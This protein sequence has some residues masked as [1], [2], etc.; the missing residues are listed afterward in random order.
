MQVLTP[1]AVCAVIVPARVAVRAPAACVPSEVPPGSVVIIE[2]EPTD[3]SEKAAGVPV[4]APCE[5]DGTVREL[6]VARA[7]PP[8]IA[9][10]AA[11][12]AT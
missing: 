11:I 2:S 10:I 8:A 5:G 4:P 9:S 3:A 12:V 6:D 1:H 7:N